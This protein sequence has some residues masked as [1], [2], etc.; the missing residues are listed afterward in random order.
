[1]TTP[2]YMA[3][4]SRSQGRSSW[5]VIFRHPI[6]SQ[7]NGKPGL[8]VRRGLGTLDEAEAQELVDQLNQLLSEPRM[9]NLTARR[10]AAVKYDEKVISAFYDPMAQ[11][12]A[13]MPAMMSAWQVRENLLPLPGKDEGY[14]RALLLGTTGVGKTTLLRQLI[15]TDPDKER[16]PSTAPAKTTIADTEI[17]LTKD[18]PF[19][20]VVTFMPRPQVR[21]YI[22]ECVVAS[23]LAYLEKKDRST[24]ERKLLEHSDQRFRLSYL[25][26]TTKIKADRTEKGKED[27]GLDGLDFGALEDTEVNNEASTD[28]YLLAHSELSADE[29]EE[30]LR[31]LNSLLDRIASLADR[32]ST[33]LTT[34]LGG[35]DGVLS[36][37]DEDAFILLLEE[38]LFKEDEFTSLV[39]DILVEIEKKFGY[40][41]LGTIEWH[42]DDWPV[43][44]TY[45]SDDRTTFIETV[46]RF[47]SNYAPN[48]GRL[49]TPLVGGVRVAGPFTP[50]WYTDDPK[51]VL[52]DGEGLG[53]TPDSA[54]SVSTS[55]T[56][57]YNDVDAIVLVDHAAQPMLAAPAQV[58]RTLVRSG[59][60]AKLIVTF[61]HF[62]EIEGDNLATI[63]LRKE[64]VVASFENTIAKIGEDMGLR[65]ERVLKEC[66]VD[67]MFFL[68]NLQER[69]SKKNLAT[70]Q[71]LIK[72]IR[73]IEAQI[74]PPV[75]T[76]VT[77][78]YDDT[79]LVLGIEKAVRDFRQ[80]WRARLK[81][82]RHPNVGPE[83]WA[84][85]KALTRRLGELNLEEY[86][87]LRPVADLL[88]ELQLHAYRFVQNPISWEPVHAP[89]EMQKTAIDQILQSLERELYGYVIERLFR[90]KKSNWYRAYAEYRGTGS[91]YQRAKEIESIYE[92]AAPIP[93]EVPDPT[94]RQFLQDIRSIVRRCIRENDGRIDDQTA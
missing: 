74:I 24:L 44:W 27:K 61:T 30:L 11:D 51:L 83:H 50:K 58:L 71:E 5:S 82:G 66:E 19:K 59:H 25:L 2:F 42:T 33:E 90:S 86:G 49:L 57:R 53:H 92:L 88:Q 36:E 21:Q 3:S 7:K 55:I 87:E 73:A 94:T 56:R 9:W 12:G 43:Y 20:A 31:I 1:M 78:V 54:A 26:G 40:L 22:E 38:E 15:G 17:I 18:L 63:S 77:P 79:T 10:E 91:T 48:F 34:R 13:D 68:E 46:R 62:D 80:P 32:T 65:A 60:H 23:V 85:I 84:R 47:S 29:Q 6:R 52:I 81:L 4:L 93:D 45:E 14:A 28:D 67:R 41:R 89:D 75:P 70:F 39:D 35:D 37:E 76:E 72:L 64:H 8:R 69:P 16:F